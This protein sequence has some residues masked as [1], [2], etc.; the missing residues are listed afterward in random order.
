MPANLN[1]LIRYKTIDRLLGTGRKYALSELIEH[2]SEA[3]ED[4]RGI[5]KTISKRT[6]QEDIR[7]LRSD[8]LGFNAPIENNSGRYFYSEPDYSIFK[9]QISN[10]EILKRVYD[11]LLILRGEMNNDGLDRILVDL[12]EVVG[13]QKIEKAGKLQEAVFDESEELRLNLNELISFSI[14]TY[15]MKDSVLFK[16]GWVLV[17]L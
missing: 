6:I 13:D 12:G 16:W 14:K 2:C 17:R 5:Y 7:V 10:S 1:A 15:M 3:L 9:T 4:T 8:I 11:F